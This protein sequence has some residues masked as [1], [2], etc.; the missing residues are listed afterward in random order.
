MSQFFT[1]GGQSI[2]VSASA[3]VLPVI[4]FRMDWLDLLA[5][6]QTLESLLQH[7]SSK[8]SILWCSVFFVIQLSHPYM[9]TGKTITSTRWTFVGKVMPK[10][11]PSEPSLARDERKTLGE[12][13][14]AVARYHT[15]PS[16]Q[17][18]K[19][20]TLK[21]LLFARPGAGSRRVAFPYH[22]SGLNPRPAVLSAVWGCCEDWAVSSR[23]V[24][25]PAGHPYIRHVEVSVRAGSCTHWFFSEVLS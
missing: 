7:H 18:H 10:P 1:S 25:L 16:Q 2:G 14:P 23:H 3:S 8:A 11:S 22:S 4:S 17:G 6:Q 5:V 12:G 20:S 24:W 13:E 15:K 21:G 19:L 9:T